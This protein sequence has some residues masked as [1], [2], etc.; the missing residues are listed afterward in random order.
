[1]GT[2]QICTCCNQ[3]Y[4]YTGK[5]GIIHFTQIPYASVIGGDETKHWICDDCYY[6]SAEEI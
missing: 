5:S 6:K 3:E 4:V 2:I 1:M